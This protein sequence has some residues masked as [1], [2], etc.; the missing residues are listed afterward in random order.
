MKMVLQ[1]E[2]TGLYPAVIRLGK[3]SI[4]GYERDFPLRACCLIARLCELKTGRSIANEE[5]EDGQ[6]KGERKRFIKEWQWALQFI[7]IHL[8][9]PFS[10]LQTLH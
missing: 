1:G 3:K 2:K 6:T 8:T 4:A 9:A 7:V 5:G 10:F